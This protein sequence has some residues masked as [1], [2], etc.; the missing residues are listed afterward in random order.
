MEQF[1]HLGDTALQ[2]LAAEGNT[3]AEE[4][5]IWRFSHL[6]RRCARPLF[7]AGGD[8]EDLTQE[9]MMGL[10]SAVRSFR[11]ELGVSFQTYAETCIR[12]RLL[13]AVKTASRYK[14]SP[15]NDALSFES[16]QF[17]EGRG[18]DV[19]DLRDMEE[20]VLAQARADEMW[21]Q[22]SAVL[23]SFEHRVLELFLTGLSYQEIAQR[24][25]K[26]GKSIDNA[27]QRIR[28]KLA[29][30]PGEISPG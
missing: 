13:T 28:K 17:E 24:L 30:R 3:A 2:A 8:S 22:F 11:S 12:H 4:A 15:L 16:S 5:L 7:L 25:G 21:N 14:H 26:S 18:R 23:S 20:R 27:V 10:L 6:V 19:S 9:G 1:S 29:Q